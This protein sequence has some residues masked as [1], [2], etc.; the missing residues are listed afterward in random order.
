MAVKK[1]ATNALASYDE[2][3]ALLA[4][5]A[6]SQ[7]ANTG[8]GASITVKA[9]KLTMSGE[10]VPNNQ[11][12]AIILDAVMLNTYYDQQMDP[13][14]PVP[15]VCYAF[16]RDEKVM[17]PHVD[18]PDP[19]SES[20]EAC[21]M[22]QWGSADRGRGKACGNTRRLAMIPAGTLDKDGDFTPY[23]LSDLKAAAIVY[24]RVPPTSISIF[25][26]YVKQL[27]TV[28]K[29]PSCLLF[30]KVSTVPDAKSQY[31]FKFEAL[32][33]VPEELIGMLLDRHQEARSG[34][35][36]PYQAVTEVEGPRRPA[37]KKKASARK[38]Y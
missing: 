34:I 17:A 37:A 6:A 32:E 38:K 12:A 4:Q 21:E 35:E 5:E 7:E 25:A 24:M 2:Q 20:C 22:N 36:F 23:D 11:L 9:G 33:E 13:D 18:A 29:K 27:S 15:P 26:N 3:I 28:L 19:K 8:G 1:P 31:K 10:E 16:G 30:T 14:D